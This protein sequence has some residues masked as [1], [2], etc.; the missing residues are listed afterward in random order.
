MVLVKS[1]IAPKVLCSAC[2]RVISSLG[3]GGSASLL[4]SLSA[5]VA[6]FNQAA[7]TS[8]TFLPASENAPKYS[9]K[10]KVHPAL[11]HGEA[12]LLNYS[13]VTAH[14]LWS[15]V[16]GRLLRVAFFT[17]KLTCALATAPSNPIRMIGRHGDQPNTGVIKTDRR[18]NR[19][20]YK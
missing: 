4:S 20:M 8:C 17:G 14:S 1:T 9:E 15:A 18:P 2:V 19:Q 10:V 12:P 7:K 3:C 16:R 13:V 5:S 6:A 11:P